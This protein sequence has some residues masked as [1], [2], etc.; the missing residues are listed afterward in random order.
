MMPI[1]SL[2]N[3]FWLVNVPFD[4]NPLW[5]YVWLIPVLAYIIA[6]SLKKEEQLTTKS[7]VATFGKVYKSFLI[8]FFGFA[9][10]TGLVSAVVGFAKLGIIITIN[11]LYMLF[12]F[13]LVQ[14]IFIKSPG[15]Y[16]L[17]LRIENFSLES[18]IRILAFNFC[19]ISPFYILFI[20]NTLNVTEE[21]ISTI[22]FFI[23]FVIGLNMA[24]R[25][26]IPIIVHIY[27][28]KHSSLLEDILK[29]DVLQDEAPPLMR[30]PRKLKF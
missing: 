21:I 20:C 24:S 15:Y 17:K 11:Y 8:N 23:L 9:L 18:K 14:N 26:L 7:S 3:P 4:E 22:V 10:F 1:M 5:A 19:K 29:I 27:A 2:Q 6:I 25:F 16:F 12:F 28:C 13:I 30:S